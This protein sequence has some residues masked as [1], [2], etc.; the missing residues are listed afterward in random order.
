MV[1][2]C[3]MAWRQQDYRVTADPPWKCA[4]WSIAHVFGALWYNSIHGSLAAR[5]IQTGGGD[6]PKKPGNRQ[7]LSIT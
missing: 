3:Q 4:L 6:G 2:R 1:T 5:L 7:V